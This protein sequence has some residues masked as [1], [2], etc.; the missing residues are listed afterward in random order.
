MR[1]RFVLT[2]PLEPEE[3]RGVTMHA[4]PGV[5]GAGE[6]IFRRVV[7]PPARVL[8]VGAGGWRS[9]L[10]SVVGR[11]LRRERGLVVKRSDI[12]GWRRHPPP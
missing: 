4:H 8:D 2:E 10:A 12:D 9:V 7:A 6:A 1:N 5:H 11:R 3:Y